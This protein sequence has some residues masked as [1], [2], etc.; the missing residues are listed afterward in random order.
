[1]NIF[2]TDSCPI[3]SAQYLDNRRLIKMVL[4]SAQLLSSAIILNNGKGFYKLTHK[5]HPATV[6][7]RSSQSNAKWLLE[8]FK[9]LCTEYT[10]RFNK[11]H[12][13]Q[14]YLNTIELELNN[15]PDK[16][17]TPFCNITKFHNEN[18]FEAYKLYLQ[19]KWNNDKIKPKWS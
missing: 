17:L 3:K 19:D 13:C 18:V 14:Q 10:K 9:A 6:W 5:N 4:E 15:I 11:V 1:M 16:G 8:H 7:T 12:K 2:V